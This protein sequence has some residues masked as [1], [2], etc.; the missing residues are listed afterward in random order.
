LRQRFNDKK[1]RTANNSIC[2]KPGWKLKHQRH[3]IIQLLFQADEV[4]SET[5]QIKEIKFS[6]VTR[7]E[8]K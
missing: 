8:L 7:T 4:L 2:A 1:A 5:K 3:I 6:K